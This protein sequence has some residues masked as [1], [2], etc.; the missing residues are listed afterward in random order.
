MIAGAGGVWAVIYGKQP[1]RTGVKVAEN[2]ATVSKT[3]ASCILRSTS[4]P[5]GSAEG[6]QE[7]AVRR[8][9]ETILNSQTFA[10][11]ERLRNF[12][13]FVVEQTLAGNA[14]QVKEY[15]IGLAV[16]HR[17]GTYD[18][19]LDPTVRVHAGKLRSKL[20]EYYAVE[21]SHARVHIDVPK[22]TYVPTFTGTSAV[23]PEDPPSATPPAGR[24]K[25][26]AV[27]ALAATATSVLALVLMIRQMAAPMRSAEWM[28]LTNFADSVAQP[29]LSPDGRLVAFI[30]GPGTFVTRGQI[31]VKSLPAG[32]P[33]QLTDDSIPKMFPAFSPD[34]SRIAYTAASGR[35]WDTFTVS[36]Q[37]GAS[38]LLL[39]NAAALQWIGPRQVLFSEIETG[40]H[41][42]VLTAVEDRTLAHD[43]YVPPNDLGMAHY[44]QLSPDRKWVLIAEM[45]ELP[46]RWLECRLVPFDGSSRGIAVG[47]KPAACT[48][49]AWSPDGR[50]MYFSADAGSG[51]HIWRQRF[52]QAAVEQ[53]TSGPTSEEGL[54]ISPDGRSLITSVGLQHSS[55]WV[56]NRKGDRQI[57]TE[58]YAT[59]SLW[60]SARSPFSPDG[61]KLYFLVRREAGQLALDWA[62]WRTDLTSGYSER[63]LPGFLL[64]DFDIASDGTT[65]VFTTRDEKLGSPALWL[66]SLDGRFA[67]RRLPFSERAEKPIL[68]PEDV[69]FFVA[70]E[71]PSKFLY[72][73]KLDGTG[74]R[75]L[76]PTPIVGL[77]SSSPNGEWFVVRL[78]VIGAALNTVVA[79]P[80]KRGP[81]IRL[82]DFCQA[83]WSPGGKFFWMAVGGMVAAG[84]GK[85]FAFALNAGQVF[86]DLPSGGIRSETDLTSIR[87]ARL[88][89]EGLS[90]I[91]PD[92]SIYAYS[93]PEAQ[94]NLYRIP[95]R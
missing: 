46:A 74:L 23:A 79:Y 82:C 9:L 80:R 41:M 67:P 13:R 34:G 21:G 91:G 48:Q 38:S 55:V 44:S 95:L 2:A 49:A 72:R 25:W 1:Y 39:A 3:Q 7:E 17:S 19:R 30:R 8:E 64:S 65:I 14:D 36:P 58:G 73:M 56:H 76:L 24:P 94:R 16:F 90:L 10:G 52:G 53:L 43:V 59:P 18:P 35:R 28:Q 61:K 60:F 33:I 5:P 32:R 31:Y 78:P 42:K 81:A 11:S 83:G 70:T 45:D 54:A 63:L 86:P 92:P 69:V 68:G 71:G 87:G 29:A 50:W 20:R 84:G 93:R 4:M 85:T 47:P 40:L 51:F 22:G 15:T 26:V 27:A 66:A 62:L 6:L 75:K 88:V 77:L 37:G 12:L 57:S 89:S